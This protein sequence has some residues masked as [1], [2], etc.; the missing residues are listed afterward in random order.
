[1]KPDDFGF[2]KYWFVKYALTFKI[3]RLI[4]YIR[5]T[6]KSIISTVFSISDLFQ[7]RCFANIRLDGSWRILCEL[8]L[9]SPSFN[10]SKIKIFKVSQ[11][12]ELKRRCCVV[13]TIRNIFCYLKTLLIIIILD[14]HEKTFYKSIRSFRDFRYFG[15]SYVR[16]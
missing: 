12:H 14:L 15:S 13:G 5:G 11:T 6:K 1:M 9:L 8:F 16:I 2:I 10:N 7:I 3:N 4:L